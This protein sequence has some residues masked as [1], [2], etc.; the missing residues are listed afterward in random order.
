M[1]TRISLTE[2]QVN[3][4][5]NLA[6]EVFPVTVGDWDAIA[7]DLL[8]LEEYGLAWCD[9]DGECGVTEMGIKFAEIVCGYERDDILFGREG[10]ENF[11]F[12]V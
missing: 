11:V 10:E 6:E 1:N 5:V 4:L 3:L 7:E 2:P 8:A 12:Y 9:Y